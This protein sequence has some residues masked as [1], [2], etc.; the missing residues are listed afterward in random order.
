MGG[1]FSA[2]GG[3]KIEQILYYRWMA[4]GEGEGEDKI[5]EKGGGNWRRRG[6]GERGKRGLGGVVRY[7]KEGG[8]FYCML[9][10]F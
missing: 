1:R 3:K 5:I 4:G 10:S 6:R 7:C 2:G 9:K 8:G